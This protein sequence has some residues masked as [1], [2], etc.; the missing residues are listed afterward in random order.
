MILRRV[1][2]KK[3]E[4]LNRTEEKMSLDALL[5][6]QQGK[7]ACV[8]GRHCSGKTRLL[9]KVI[10]KQYAIIVLFFFQV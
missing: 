6:S 1:Q 2:A 10:S 9:R 4:F 7:F 8:Y 3:I 5:D